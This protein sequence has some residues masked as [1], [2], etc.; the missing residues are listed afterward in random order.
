MGEAVQPLL[1]NVVHDSWDREQS[2][3]LNHDDG[4][5]QAEGSDMHGGDDDWQ[6]PIEHVVQH[7][8]EEDDN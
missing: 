7:V 8:I 2:D 1:P 6:L 3:S 5:C 4:A